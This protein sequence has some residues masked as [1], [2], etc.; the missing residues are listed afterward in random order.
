M[1][2]SIVIVSL[3]G[4]SRI[5]MPL[6]ALAACMPRAAEVIV[7]DNGSHD[8]LSEFVAERYPWVKLVRAPRNLGFAGGNNLGIVNATGEVIVLL[9][10]DT[11]PRANW[12]APIQEALTQ[13]RTLG[14]V[15]CSLLYPGAEKIQHRGGVIHANGLTDHKE[16]NAEW[17]EDEDVPAR[18]DAPYV[19][20]AAM[21]IRRAVIDRV[22]M[23]DAGYWPIYFEEVDFCERA[24]RDHWGCA[25]VPRS[26][27]IHHESQTTV[28]FSAKF[29]KTYH[30]NR[31]RFLLKNR[32]LRGWIA[33]LRAEVRW[34]VQH[35]PWDQLWPCALAY[36]WA[37][38]HVA[39]VLR[40]RWKGR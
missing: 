40:E 30:R 17:K 25:V 38:V 19:T 34:F 22:G 35:R 3:N 11:E 39:D 23:L 8:G 21:A 12:L 24:V 26:I 18:I 36:A 10:D 1:R 7:V 37:P 14:I 15:G 9:N 32:R 6:D 2:F 13:D 28:R 33:A 29:L 16:W 31:V 20:G 4:R 27:V 5:A